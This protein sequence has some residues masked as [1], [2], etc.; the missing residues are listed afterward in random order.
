VGDG[1]VRCCVCV[2]VNELAG[3]FVVEIGIRRDWPFLSFWDKRS[4]PEH[5]VRL[6]VDGRWVLASRKG[7]LGD[8]EAAWLVAAAVLN[9]ETVTS[10]AVSG[11]GSL[12]LEMTGGAHLEISGEATHTA[13]GE[14]WWLDRC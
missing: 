10:V 7:S 14:P 2:D 8:D 1:S 6:F 12:V 13:V 11:T 4:M 5:E 3:A 9:G